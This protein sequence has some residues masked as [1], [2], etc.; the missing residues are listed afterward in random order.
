VCQIHDAVEI[1]LIH[2]KRPYPQ[3]SRWYEH[4]SYPPVYSERW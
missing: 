3:L 4:P 2:D 1:V